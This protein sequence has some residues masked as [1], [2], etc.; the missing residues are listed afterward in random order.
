[1][2]PADGCEDLVTPLAKHLPQCQAF[3]DMGERVVPG[4]EEKFLRLHTKTRPVRS[5]F[6]FVFVHEVGQ[7]INSPEYF[8]SL[9]HVLHLKPEIALEQDHD[10]DRIQ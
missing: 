8:L 10:F 6:L 7:R 2:F 3:G 5:G 4:N 9:I 1:M